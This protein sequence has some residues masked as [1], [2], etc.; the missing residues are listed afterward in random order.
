MPHLSSKKLTAAAIADLE[1]NL[2][3]VLFDLTGTQRKKIFREILTKTE[4]VMIAKRIALVLLIGKGYSPYK[5]S[6][7]LGISPSTAERFQLMFTYGKFK[8]TSLWVK[9]YKGI[10]KL[11]HLLGGILAPFEYPRK[12]LSQLLREI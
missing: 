9:R 1:R 7:R 10:N 3:I 12:S 11:L 6:E 2:D 5:I 4:R 8:A